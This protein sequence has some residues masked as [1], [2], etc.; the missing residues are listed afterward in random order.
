MTFVAGHGREKYLT[1]T[2]LGTSR[3]LGWR[4][5]L[6]E[7]WSHCEGDLGAVEPRDTEVV[8]MLQGLGRVRRRGDGK[9]QLHNSVPGMV[10]LCPAGI[11]EDMIRLGG[12][13]REMLHMYLPSPSLS[14]TVLRESDVDFDKVNL[15]YEG[16]FHD[17]LIEQIARSVYW[18]MIEPGPVGSMSVESLACALGVHVLRHY[19]NFSP[20]SAPLPKARGA[21]DPR[22][23]RRAREFIEAHLCEALSITTL[24]SEVNLSPYHFARAFKAATGESPHRYI[25][26][27]RINQGKGAAGATPD[28]TGRNFRF[29]RIF[30][31]GPFHSLVQAHCGRH[32]GRL[33]RK[34]R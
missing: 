20:E 3:G 9:I 10:W 7:R 4:G 8:V 11:R 28:S 33:P 26:S 2:Q 22:R 18:E 5:L 32:A 15:R 14:A 27:L 17:P 30:I 6:A 34:L 31:P 23:L 1:G 24:A 13:H 21:L 16:G 25:T 12:E 19:S 29:M